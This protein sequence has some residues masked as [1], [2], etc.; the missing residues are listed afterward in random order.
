MVTVRPLELEY[1]RLQQR[2]GL[3]AE[4][5][6]SRALPAGLTDGLFIFVQVTLSTCIMQANERVLFPLRS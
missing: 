2:S 5:D 6:S 4:R 3:L 1:C